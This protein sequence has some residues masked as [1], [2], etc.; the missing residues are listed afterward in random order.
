MFRRMIPKTTKQLTV[1]ALIIALYVVI[2]FFTQSISFGAIQ[3]RIATALYALA[4]PFPFLIIPLGVAN[5]LS[6]FIGGMG[7]FDIVGGS[8]VG[9]VTAFL[10]ALLRFV[11]EKTENQS[12]KNVTKL[13]VFFPILIIPGC[14]VPLWL[15][16]ILSSAGQ[17]V[18]YL[19]L[20]ISLSLGQ[21]I[22]AIAGCIIIFCLEK[23]FYNFKIE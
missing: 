10:I 11:S 16:P 4:Y 2:L 7:I 3:C 22:P 18:T 8:L 15:T 1:S 5:F 13:F 14:A 17:S 20:C 19:G 6:N 12:L 23:R 9:C 21:L